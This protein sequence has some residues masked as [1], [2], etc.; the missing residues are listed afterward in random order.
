MLVNE[1]REPPAKFKPTQ[2]RCR[3]LYELVVQRNE[4][5]DWHGSTDIVHRS[6][7]FATT[8]EA[9]TFDVM[10]KRAEHQRKQGSRFL[11]RVMPVLILENTQHCLMVG[12]RRTDKPLLGLMKH[13]EFRDFG[14]LNWTTIFAE[15]FAFCLLQRGGFILTSTD[16][17]AVANLEKFDSETPCF[18]FE[19]RPHPK[20]ASLGWAGCGRV[21]T[22]ELLSFVAAVK[23]KKATDAKQPA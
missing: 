4:W 10:S 1:T 8:R 7:N 12:E 16:R 9:D 19:S 15:L 2:I 21:S 6:S 3:K 22:D 13:P 23:K 18:H 5:T 14:K 11:L 17:A 20:A